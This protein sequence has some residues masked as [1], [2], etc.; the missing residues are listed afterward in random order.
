MI[1]SIICIAFNS[2]TY[3]ATTYQTNDNVILMSATDVA[4]IYNC[5][6]IQEAKAETTYENLHRIGFDIKHISAHRKH[7][8][9]Y[10]DAGAYVFTNDADNGSNRHNDVVLFNIQGVHD[11]VER[12][13]R[14]GI[15]DR[16]SDFMKTMKKIMGCE[17]INIV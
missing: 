12:C 14:T 7:A 1:Q 16:R 2:T 9:K 10:D 5:V 4:L 15:I 3:I 6:S 17:N 11:Y 13:K 8:A